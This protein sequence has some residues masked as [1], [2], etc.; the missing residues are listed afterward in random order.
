MSESNRIH[1]FS[2]FPGLLTNMGQT[3]GEHW[4]LGVFKNKTKLNKTKSPPKKPKPH[5]N[6]LQIFTSTILEGGRSL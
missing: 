3:V 6:F 1:S 2:D 4:F 5:N